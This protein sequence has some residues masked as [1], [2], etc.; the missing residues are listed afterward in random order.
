MIARKGELVKVTRSVHVFYA[1]VIM[2]RNMHSTIIKRRCTTINISLTTTMLLHFRVA[3]ASSPSVCRA[4][5]KSRFSGLASVKQLSVANFLCA[6][7]FYCISSH[8]AG[9]TLASL[10]MGFVKRDCPLSR[11]LP[12]PRC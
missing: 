11:N 1:F 4:I 10:E 12:V 7:L 3:L 8:L 2:L 6:A 9:H 5:L